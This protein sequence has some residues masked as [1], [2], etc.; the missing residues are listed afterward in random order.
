MAPL[1][2]FAFGDALNK[3]GEQSEAYSN[4]PNLVNSVRDLALEFVILGGVSGLSRCALAA[5]WS[6]AGERQV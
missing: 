6:I 3:L 2:V 5:F 4:A 1:F